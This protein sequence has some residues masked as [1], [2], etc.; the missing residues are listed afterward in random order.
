M[1]FNIDKEK[2]IDTKLVTEKEHPTLPL[3]IY[4]Y[5]PECQFSKS[6]DDVT[7]MCRGL[8]VHK[9]TRE[10]IAR[11]FKKF[12]NYEEHMTVPDMPPVPSESPFVY[13]KMDG[14]LGILYWFAGNPYIATRGSFVSDQATWANDFIQR[15]S[16]QSAIHKLDKSKTYLFEI[17]YPE[18]R[19]V[20]SYGSREDLVLLAVLDT[21]TGSTDMEAFLDTEFPFVSNLPFTSYEN[22][23]GLN[24]TNQEGFV[25]HYPKTDM[26]VKIKFEDYV[27]LHKV[28]TGLSQ[29]GIWE[30]LRDRKNPISEDIPDEMHEWIKSVQDSLVEKYHEINVQVNHDFNAIAV[31]S[32]EAVFERKVLPT[33]EDYSMIISE[34]WKLDRKK[35]AELAKEKKYPGLLFS[36]LDKKDYSQAIWKMVRPSGQVTF[37]KDIDA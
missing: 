26:R 34:K 29:I 3:L 15:P 6:W 35:F 25:L 4:N 18:N 23:K 27:K 10:I 9:V 32:C 8:I 31:E 22:L 28:M 36:K 16:I 7:M 2:Y 11:P 5:T 19:I 13:P 33:Q 24:L 30:M 37:R 14:S 17:I 21:E 1:I 12:F 20:V